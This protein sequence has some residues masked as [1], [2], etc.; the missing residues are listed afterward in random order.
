MTYY[1]RLH[2]C[3]VVLNSLVKYLSVLMLIESATLD[4]SVLMALTRSSVVCLTFIRLL[5]FLL[6]LL[7]VNQPRVFSEYYIEF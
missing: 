7:D 6:P 4:L 5:I 3:V 2:L 1:S